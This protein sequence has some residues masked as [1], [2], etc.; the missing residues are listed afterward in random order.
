MKVTKNL[1]EQEIERLIRIKEIYNQTHTLQQTATILKITRERVRQLLRK[2][3]NCGLYHYETYRSRKE[4]ELYKI[5]SRETLVKEMKLQN[6]TDAIISKLGITEDE[7]KKLLNFFNIDR[8]EYVTISKQ[9]KCLR[10]YSNVVDILGHHPTTTELSSKREWRNLWFRINRLWG[11]VDVFRREYGIEKQKQKMALK[12]QEK[13]NKIREQNEKLK[14]NI[15]ETIK[16]N[17]SLSTKELSIMLGIKKEL[18]H[19]KFLKKMVK[20]GTLIT[21]GKNNTTRYRVRNEN[22]QLKLDL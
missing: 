4:R 19:N 13:W 8:K 14:K 3:E 6:N 2:G 12:I 11:G 20:E 9:G 15:L 21:I 18:L 1:S 22:K 17:C 10:Q 5:F 7:F 16:N